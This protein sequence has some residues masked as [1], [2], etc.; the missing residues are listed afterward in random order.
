MP[1]LRL[2]TILPKLNSVRCCKA[3]RNSEVGVS[4]AVL[5]DDVLA[6]AT[7]AGAV[8]TCPAEPEPGGDPVSAASLPHVGPCL[9]VGQCPRD[10][11]LVVTAGEDGAV[12]VVSVMQ[13]QVPLVSRQVGAIARA[14]GLNNPLQSQSELGA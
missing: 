11:Q 14:C 1:E 9:A 4:G 6:V 3:N 12:N 10:G 8:L 7:E 2:H 13:P 5:Y